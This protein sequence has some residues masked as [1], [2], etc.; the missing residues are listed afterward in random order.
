MIEVKMGLVIKRMQKEL[1]SLKGGLDNL[2]GSAI[3]NQ[4]LS[5]E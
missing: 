5:L 3:Y 4:K 2:H 1:D